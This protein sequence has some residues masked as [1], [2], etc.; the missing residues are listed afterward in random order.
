MEA[1]GRLAGGIAHDFNNL[2]TVI[3]GYAEL[4][5]LSIDEKDPIH[6]DLVEIKKAGGRA[7][8]LTEQLL[9]FSR[10]KILQTGV[11]NLNNLIVELE[12][13][14]RPIIGEDIELKTVLDE[15]LK[16]VNADAGSIEQVIINLVV[17]ARDAM[18][19]GG[20]LLIETST[21]NLDSLYA[22]EH[23]EVEPGFY[24]CMAV[25]DSGRG[26]EPDILPNIF[27][28]FFTTKE[29]NKGT[30]LGLSTVYGIVRQSG[31]S[32]TVYSEPHKGTT[33]KVY[34]P[35][36][37]EE[38]GQSKAATIQLDDYS[39]SETILLAED[40]D[41]VR[42]FSVSILEKYGYRVL[43]AKN[44]SAALKLCEKCEK[45]GTS[46]DIVFTDVVMPGMSG[47]QLAEKLTLLYP[48]IKVL[49][50]SGYTENSIVHH[51]VLDEGIDFIQ[52]PYGA[53]ELLAKIRE[54]LNRDQHAA[55]APER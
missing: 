17:N 44:G 8:L 9:A 32:V 45:E 3:N 16:N 24:T 37:Q 41:L 30:G 10:R 48:R 53:E 46:P 40:E 25:T 33:F 6:T 23:S 21:V 38:A 28:P 31:G 39:G 35:Q 18:A 55:P 43:A 36:V 27:E 49:Y 52:K 7:A 5:L 1:V 13:M 4:I 15:K 2:L 50:A 34:L 42:N 14:L 22:R 51:G 54:I 47:N 29:M 12:N 26:I 20:K 19:D 11:F